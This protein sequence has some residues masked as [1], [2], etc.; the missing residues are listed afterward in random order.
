VWLKVM[1]WKNAVIKMCV[2][3]RAC[4]CVCVSGKHVLGDV[5]G[6]V[7]GLAVKGIERAQHRNKRN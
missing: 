5:G 6:F 2:G 7:G 3:V 1:Q 4:A